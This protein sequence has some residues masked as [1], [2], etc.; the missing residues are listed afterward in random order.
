M[1]CLYPME[2][3]CGLAVHAPSVVLNANALI[4]R[5]T[6]QAALQPE[7]TAEERRGKVRIASTFRK[8]KLTLK[9]IQGLLVNTYI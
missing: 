8:F 6:R 2:L 1:Q 7:R 4:F 5:P 3:S 9:I